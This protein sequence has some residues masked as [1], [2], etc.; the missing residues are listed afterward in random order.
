MRQRI[1]KEFRS[2]QLPFFVALAATFGVA[3]F[4][5]AERMLYVFGAESSGFFAGFSSFALFS[6]MVLIPALLFGAEFQHRTLQLL[7]SQPMKRSRIWAEKMGVGLFSLVCVGLA[8]LL[9]HEVLK[10]PA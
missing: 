9:C 6:S 8:L 5:H 4:K 10:L 7:L 2:I 3:F 1:A